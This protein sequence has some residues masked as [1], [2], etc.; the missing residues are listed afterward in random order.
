MNNNFHHKS[1]VDDGAVIGQGT[2]VWAFT[3]I[4]SRARIGAD[5]N[6]CDHVFTENNVQVGDRVTIKCGVQFWNGVRLGDDVFVGPN[7]TFTNDKTPR[8]KEYPSNFLE[9]YIQKGAS[10]GANATILPGVKIGS[11]AMVGAGA[12]VTKDVPPNA[13][14]S[15]NPARIVGYMDT[16]EKRTNIRGNTN[17]ET[18]QVT[19]VKLYQM[20]NV[21]DLRGDL[22]ALE[23]EKEL[24]F[25]PKR[26]FF[27]SNV[28]DSSV[29]G[30]NAHKNCHQF[31]L[32]VHGSVAVVVDDGENREEF[33]LK[34]AHIGLHIPP[35]V[36]ATQ[37]KYSS[38][39][40]LLVLASHEYDADDCL[41]DYDEYLTYLK[42]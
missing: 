31:L 36:W 9:T 29:R 5:C 14:V 7:A 17:L 2:R 39:A 13:I 27:V 18:S 11:S 33:F 12:V 3:H 22:T 10:I 19:G 28:P 40:V 35:K 15:G 8:S 24:P 25:S 41:R 32:C 42:S 37:Y 34:E 26:L 38:D 20:K 4:L 1:L 6:I 23:W 30:E 16:K 21:E